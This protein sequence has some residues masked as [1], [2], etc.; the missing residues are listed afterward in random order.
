MKAKLVPLGKGKH[1]AELY[2]IRGLKPT[3]YAFKGKVKHKG[4]I[5]EQRLGFRGNKVV[6][7][8]FIKPKK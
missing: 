2:G 8:G 1:A 6:E 7:V 4:R 5:M 3:R